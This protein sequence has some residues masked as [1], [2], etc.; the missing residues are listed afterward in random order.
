[1][2]LIG[3]RITR[4]RTGMVL[5]RNRCIVILFLDFFSFFIR[6]SSYKW[7]VRDRE[8]FFSLFFNLLGIFN[9]SLFYFRH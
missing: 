8:I 5:E 2:G 6:C 3:Y 1:M 4:D 9:R 7:D